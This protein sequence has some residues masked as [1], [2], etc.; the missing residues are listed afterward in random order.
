MGLFIGCEKQKI[1]QEVDGKLEVNYEDVADEIIR[2]HVIANSDSDEDQ[3]LKLKIRDKVVEY[4]S[5]KVSGC[6]TLDD[7]RKEILNNQK[8]MEDI[9]RAVI[10]ENGYNYEVTSMLSR[11]N[12]PDK[13]Y[14]DL[15]FPQGEYEA[16]RI[17]IGKASGQNWWCVMFPPLCFVDGT[18]DAITTNKTEEKLEELMDEAK[19][20]KDEEKK[21][22]FKFKLLESLKGN[23]NKE[24]K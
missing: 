22:Q 17:L 21:V 8:A 18:K 15:V 16:F 23:S 10:K 12:F 9:A 4:A 20:K 3:A 19:A 11:E 5:T 24:S 6:K 14:G 2:F 13:M 7:A 1:G